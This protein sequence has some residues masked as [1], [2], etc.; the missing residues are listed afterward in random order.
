[1]AVK[2]KDGWATRSQL[3]RQEKAWKRARK[4]MM[5]KLGSALDNSAELDKKSAEIFH[6]MDTDKNGG[7]DREELKKGFKLAGVELKNK[8][9]K[10][11]L[12]EADRDGNGLIDLSEFQELMRL[13]VDRW[14][15]RT[16]SEVCSIL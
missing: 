3:R 9:A 15:K 7:I 14:K 4:A 16:Q 11:M 10:S 8:E 12:D 2:T 13:E 6:E 1:M 5:T